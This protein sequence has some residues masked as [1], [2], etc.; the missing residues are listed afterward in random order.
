MPDL[1][2]STLFQVSIVELNFSG[3][4]VS[5]VELNGRGPL[6]GCPTD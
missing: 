2:L 5:I 4:K 6:A 1:S 3:V